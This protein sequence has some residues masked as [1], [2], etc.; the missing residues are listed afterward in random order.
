MDLKKKEALRKKFN[1]TDEMVLPYDP[2][3]IIDVP[4]YG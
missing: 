2:I 1:I 3:P 4:E